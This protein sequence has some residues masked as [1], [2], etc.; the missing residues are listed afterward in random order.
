[1]PFIDAIFPLIGIAGT[2][3]VHRRHLRL[4]ARADVRW[5]AWGAAVGLV[6]AA[7]GALW[8]IGTITADEWSSLPRIDQSALHYLVD[9]P[10]LPSRLHRTLEWPIFTTLGL[11]GIRPVH[12]LLYCAAA[13]LLIATGSRTAGGIGVVVAFS[14]LFGHTFLERMWE[15]RAY[16]TMLLGCCWALSMATMPAKRFTSPETRLV[17][18]LLPLS[19]ASLD[20]PLC[21]TLAL[22]YLLS[23]WR[24]GELGRASVLTFGWVCITLLPLAWGALD[25]HQARPQSVRW[26]SLLGALVWLVPLLWTIRQHEDSRVAEATTIALICAAVL[27]ALGILADSGKTFLFLAPWLWMSV[28]PLVPSA[29]R[30]RRWVCW[31]VVLFVLLPSIGGST[32]SVYARFIEAQSARSI[33]QRLH[34]AGVDEVL[35]APAWRAEAFVSAVISLRDAKR[36]VWTVTAG[37]PRR[38]LSRGAARCTAGEVGVVHI[39][40]DLVCD[41]PALSQAGPWRAHRCGVRESGGG[42]LQ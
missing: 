34:D 11:Q 36:R 40:A 8:W 4:E 38:Y 42:G 23:A 6:L 19:L 29:P 16:A 10:G 9:D 33:D 20:N 25:A 37:I 21:W 41:C 26:I 1:M 2:L 30:A 39:D 35:F 14:V 22:G 15:S 12:G 5:A 13:L 3:F 31:L 7:F 24:R 32:H 17:A 27:V 18:V 28:L